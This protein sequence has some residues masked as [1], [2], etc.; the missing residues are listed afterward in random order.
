LDNGLPIPLTNEESL[1][2]GFS[3]VNEKSSFVESGSVGADYVG[4]VEFG[5]EV[6]LVVNR[7]AHAIEAFHEENHLIKFVK[8]FH[9]QYIWLFFSGFQIPEHGKHES[10]VFVVS[11]D[12]STMFVTVLLIF[13]NWRICLY[14]IQ[15][16]ESGKSSVKETSRLLQLRH[17]LLVVF[18]IDGKVLPIQPSVFKVR[19]YLI[20]KMIWHFC[21]VVEPLE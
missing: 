18:M 16:Q 15:I 2:L 1:A 4:A 17:R 13:K 9:E 19:F 7:V 6:V 14:K 21:S 12:V 5:I 11:P 8:F 3:L 20:F 10:T